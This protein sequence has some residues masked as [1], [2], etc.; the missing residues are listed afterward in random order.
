MFFKSTEVVQSAS[1]GDGPDRTT[2]DMVAVA[3][4][5]WGVWPA[6]V[7]AANQVCIDD[8]WADLALTFE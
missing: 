6:P 8:Q 4:E 7:R 1:E 2:C 3:P 5:V